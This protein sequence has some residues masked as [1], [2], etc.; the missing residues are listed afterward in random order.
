[1]KLQ[2]KI[3]EDLKQAITDRNKDRVELLKVVV[4]ELSR[5][6]TKEV[7]DEDVL[8]KLKMVKEGAIACG[9]TSEVVILN[10]YLP[11]MMS[12]DEMRVHVNNVISAN[13]CTGLSDIGKVMKI[14]NYY[15]PTLDKAYTSK[16]A[17][18]TLSSLK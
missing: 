4:A 1:M 12:E 7:S 11:T 5:Y 17:K 3:N 18:E 2:T 9:N 13:N 15:G 10:E 16:Y 14:L 6:P 8:K